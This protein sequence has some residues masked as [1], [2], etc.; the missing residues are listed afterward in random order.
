MN[1]LRRLRAER[2][3]I[4][5][6]AAL[7]TTMMLVF[8]ALT[9][10]VGIWLHTKTKLQADVDAMALAGAQRLPSTGTAQTT[11]EE[12]ASENGVAMAEIED[13]D[14]NRDCSGVERA[15]IITVRGK[16]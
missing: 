3:Q 2:G 13:I 12:Y 6:L 7:C 14:F 4:L 15:N 11:A 1:S 9:I 16:R 8:A 5:V 10:D